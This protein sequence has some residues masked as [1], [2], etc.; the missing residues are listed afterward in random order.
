M[1]TII[2]LGDKPCP[3]G[4]HKAACAAVEDN[5]VVETQYGPK[6]K[7]TIKWL[8]QAGPV[9]QT[10]EVTRRYTR[11]LHEKAILRQHL[12]DWIG[13]LTPDQLAQGVDLDELVGKMALVQVAHT[14]KG[15]RTFAN[16]DGVTRDP[17]AKP[18][19]RKKGDSGS[20]LTADEIPF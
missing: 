15:D 19:T 14:V 6:H 20:E 11:S 16:V 17:D 13:P 5:G 9:N 8:A 2:T 7:I 1:S 4:I 3:V 10:F 12:D 18:A